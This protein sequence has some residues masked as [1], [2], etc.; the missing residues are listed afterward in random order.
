VIELNEQLI[1]D[2]EHEIL[3]LKGNALKDESL[4]APGIQRAKNLNSAL[5]DD[6]DNLFVVL[7]AR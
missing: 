6:A 7:S 3:F 4:F 2:N 5:P 1:A